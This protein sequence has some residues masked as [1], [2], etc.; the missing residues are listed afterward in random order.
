MSE[1]SRRSQGPEQVMSV[2]VAVEA[3][4]KREASRAVAARFRDPLTVNETRVPSCLIT[5]T[6][7]PTRSSPR[8]AKTAEPVHQLT[9][10]LMMAFPAWPGGGPWLNQAT[11][12]EF[13]GVARLRCW[14]RPRAS[15]AVST[16]IRGMTS[17][18]GV[19]SRRGG[20]AVSAGIAVPGGSAGRG[21]GPATVR[22][23]VVQVK[24]STTAR[25]NG[26]FQ[27]K[28]PRTVGSV[29]DDPPALWAQTEHSPRPSLSLTGCTGAH[30]S[31]RKSPR[32]RPPDV[33]AG[34][35]RGRPHDRRRAHGRIS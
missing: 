7:S 34:H 24:V 17:R 18:T 16:E 28:M 6:A 13:D 1:P 33:P 15:I 21:A 14:S 35:P 5:I 12:L 27:S 2:R 25:S 31:P 9:W 22:G 11:S 19:E 29:E 23:A 20:A 32:A 30:S 8:R 3:G 4:A 26:G 10:P